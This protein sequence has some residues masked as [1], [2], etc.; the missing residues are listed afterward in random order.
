MTKENKMKHPKRFPNLLFSHIHSPETKRQT[1][2]HCE[3]IGR[4]KNNQKKLES[5]I[6]EMKKKYPEKIIIINHF[7]HKISEEEMT[8][9]FPS[10][11]ISSIL[12]IP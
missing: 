7:P 8:Q 5:V 12:D 9:M 6:K 4:V 10:L 11:G 3:Y 1:N 2:L